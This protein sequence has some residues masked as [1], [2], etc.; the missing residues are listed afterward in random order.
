MDPR[1]DDERQDWAGRGVSALEESTIASHTRPMTIELAVDCLVCGVPLT[2]VI[3]TALSSL[4][5]G[6][7]PR[8]PNCCTRCNTHIEEGRLVEITMLF[9]D[10][11]GFTEFTNRV[12]AEHSYELVDAY[13]RKAAAVVAGHGAFIDKFMGDSIMAFFNVPIKRADHSAAAFAAACELQ[14]SMPALSREL[15]FELKA[16]IG[17]ASGYAR[18]GRLGSDDAKDYTAI[19]EVVNQAARLQAQA[20]AGEILVSSCV[21]EKVRGAVPGVPPESLALKGFSEPV[22]AHRLN[23][24]AGRTNPSIP[25]P[26]IGRRRLGGGAL[27]MAILGGGCLGKIFAGSAALAFGL[28]SSSA[29][30]AL[31][32]RYDESAMRLP[33]VIAASIAA[34]A[35]LWLAARE[36]RDRARVEA[37]HGCIVPSVREKRRNIAVTAGSLVALV[38]VAIELITHYHAHG[39]L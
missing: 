25:V 16:A 17:I 26:L 27:V 6:R 20:R 3:G 1:C 19:G 9:A 12:G 11:S 21:Y 33:L 32:R 10:L 29:L 37:R 35:S 24:A 34:I 13:L 7:S 31:A 30:L 23:A 39:H 18:V 28:G 38:L 15:G 8:N 4:G 22:V 2:G 5:L 36:R 14:N